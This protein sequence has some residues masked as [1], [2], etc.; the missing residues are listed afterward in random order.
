MINNISYTSLEG[1]ALLILM[2]L[3][4][5]AFRENWKM[6]DTNTVKSWFIK[7]WIY[8]LLSSISFFIIVLVPMK[9]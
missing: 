5:K 4:G 7:A 6:K 2:V 8:G 1:L 9:N 3:F